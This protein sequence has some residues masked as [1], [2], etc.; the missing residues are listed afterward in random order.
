MTGPAANPTL[1]APLNSVP[2][3]AFK[4][5]L[6]PTGAANQPNESQHT[7][8]APP[9]RAGDQYLQGVYASSP[10]KTWANSCQT[11]SGS[12]NSARSLSLKAAAVCAPPRRCTCSRP[13]RPCAPGAPEGECEGLRCGRGITA[14]IVRVVAWLEGRSKESSQP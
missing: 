1:A 9:P 14:R 5:L 10:D 6:P 13:A 8:I 3:S 4:S 11:D 12:S 7:E 2:L